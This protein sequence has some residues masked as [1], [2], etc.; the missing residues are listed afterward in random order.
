MLCGIFS[1]NAAQNWPLSSTKG[2]PTLL[3]YHNLDF[4]KYF[5]LPKL[6]MGIFDQWLGEYLYH[7][8]I[9]NSLIFYTHSSNFYCYVWMASWWF[10]W[11]GG[12]ALRMSEDIFFREFILQKTCYFCNTIEKWSLNMVHWTIHFKVILPKHKYFQQRQNTSK[13]CQLLRQKVTWNTYMDKFTKPKHSYAI[14]ILTAKAEDVSSQES[15][16]RMR[17]IRWN[18]VESRVCTILK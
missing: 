16:A 2:A 5:S 15:E 11:T 10:L 13:M 12:C 8:E 1:F 7:E 14:V 4:G 3:T 9:Q 17:E 18:E 6:N